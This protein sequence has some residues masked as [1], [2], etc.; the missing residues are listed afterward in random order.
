MRS[1]H[2]TTCLLFSVDDSPGALFDVLRHFA[3]RG[4]NLKR[5]Q[6]RPVHGAGWDYLFYVEVSGHITD[7]AVVTALEAVKRATKYLRVLG[8]FPSAD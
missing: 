4:I 6:S 1:G 5:L 7:R 3:E 2:D 8:S